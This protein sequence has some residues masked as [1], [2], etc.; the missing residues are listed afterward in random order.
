MLTG[1]LMFCRILYIVVPFFIHIFGVGYGDIIDW[2]AFND[3]IGSTSVNPNTTEFTDYL[4]YTSATSGLLVNDA[5]V[6][7][8]GMPT[9]T[10]S[11]PI[12]TAIQ[13][14]SRTDYGS[15]PDEDTDAYNIFN[16]RVDFIGTILQ[17]SS[18]SA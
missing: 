6:S 18:S 9:V 14:V 1:N 5:T 3:C 7:T 15:T 10:F 13:P 2:T 4:D 16:E 12:D 8:I 11:I 17:Y